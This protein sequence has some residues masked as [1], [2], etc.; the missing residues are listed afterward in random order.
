VLQLIDH[1]GDRGCA[2]IA[3]MVDDLERS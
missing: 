3:A 1:G 2:A